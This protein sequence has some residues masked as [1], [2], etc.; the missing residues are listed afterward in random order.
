MKKVSFLFIVLIIIISSCQKS[1]VKYPETRKDSTSDVYFGVEVKDP[2]R[3]LEDESSNET[4]Q[5]IQDQNKVTFEYLSKIPYRDKIK[6]R[7]TRI[8]DYE[9]ISTPV[10]K[11][12]YYFFYKNDG[13]QEQNVLYY[14]KNLSD[15]PTA[16]LNPNTFSEDGTISLTDFGVSSDGKY[17]AYSISKS[18]SDWNEIFVKNIQTGEILK[19]HLINVKFSLISWYNDGFF[20]SRY[21]RAQNSEGLSEINYNQKIYYHQVGTDQ[22]LDELVFEDQR[23]PNRYYLA[24]VTSDEKYLIISESETTSGN[25]IYIKNLRIENKD[26][27]K[28][29]TS[30]EYEYE[31]I[32]HIDDNLIV[33]TNYKAPKYKLIK[34]NVKSL[35][36]GNWRDVIPEKSEVLKFA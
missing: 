30:F 31:V 19:D 28:L 29:T 1:P 3:W 16:I 18:G 27:T 33:M 32:D 20:Y 34:I 25:A 9:R 13:L 10:Y 11:G 35:E 4:R 22:L 14:F 2:Y 12:G 6:N 21:N 26:F 17:L 36:I 7:L 24:Y 23:Y 8:L 5:W 15:E